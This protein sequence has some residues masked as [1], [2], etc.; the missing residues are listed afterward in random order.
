MKITDIIA[1]S[2][3]TDV[4]GRV[5]KAGNNFFSTVADIGD[6]TILFNA[7]VFGPTGANQWEIDF[8][9]KTSKG[10]TYGKSGSG[11]EMQVFAFV[12]DS[13]KE[14]VSKYHPESVVFNSHKADQN[15]SKLYARMMKRV[16]AVLPGYIP[17]PVSSTDSSDT[18]TIIKDK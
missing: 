8:L 13:L 4:K 18:F 12:I 9:E 3:N 15:R 7:A 14:L 6:R 11:S 16:P 1:E 5:V 17:A 2:F 10:P